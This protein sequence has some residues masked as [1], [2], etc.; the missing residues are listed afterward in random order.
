M[1]KTMKTMLI[2]GGYG[3]IATNVIKCIEQNHLPYKVIVF[4]MCESHPHGITSPVI[5]KSYSG[6]FSNGRCIERIFKENHIDI[7]LHSISTTVASTSENPRYDIESNVFPSLFVMEM[8]VKYGVKDIVFISSGGAIYGQQKA[9][10][11]KEHDV[12]FPISPYGVSKSTIEQYLMLYHHQNKLN[13]LILRL[14]NPYGFYHYS[15][16]QG[17]INVAL[18]Y[19]RENRVFNV[20]GDGEGRKDYIWIEDF[21]DI[22]FRLLD[23]GI[24]GVINIGSGELL[25]INEILNAIKRYYPD[26]QWGY[27]SPQELDVRDFALDLS[28]LNRM[29]PQRRKISFEEGLKVLVETNR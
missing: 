18:Q 4:D 15:M 20:Y 29:L 2:F 28:K 8:M 10:P 3:F 12:V 5:C 25:S 17:I 1:E 21:A 22:F 13:P 7:V 6:D 27:Q 23:A 16:R 24:S 9:E 19:A 14:S 26:F 11:H